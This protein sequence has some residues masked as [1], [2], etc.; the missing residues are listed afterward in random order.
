MRIVLFLV[1]FEMRNVFLDLFSNFIVGATQGPQLTTLTPTAP[2]T[3]PPTAQPTPPPTG[4]PNCIVTTNTSSLNVITDI[5]YG[6]IN[7]LFVWTLEAYKWHVI[8]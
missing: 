4:K 3:A 8:C 5:N 6:R 1:P 2:S 7:K